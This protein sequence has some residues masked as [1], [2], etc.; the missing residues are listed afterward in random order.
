MQLS[1]FLKER[2]PKVDMKDASL[3]FTCWLNAHLQQTT[4]ILQFSDL[5]FKHQKY[6][7]WSLTAR[8][9]LSLALEVNIF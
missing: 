8:L 7:M 2:G 4:D 1:E 6:K 9:K 5:I 3:D